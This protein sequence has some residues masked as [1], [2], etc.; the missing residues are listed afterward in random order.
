[1]YASVSQQKLWVR[2]LA[3]PSSLTELLPAATA[4]AVSPAGRTRRPRRQS[5]A[6]SHGGAVKVLD[7]IKLID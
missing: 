2:L 6:L 1:M 5:A 3:G 4:E 7:L